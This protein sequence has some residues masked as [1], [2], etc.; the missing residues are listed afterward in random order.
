MAGKASYQRF[1]IECLLFAGKYTYKCISLFK[2]E[3]DQIFKKVL[4]RLDLFFQEQHLMNWIR[5]NARVWEPFGNSEILESSSEEGDSSEEE[6]LEESSPIFADKV[7]R[8]KK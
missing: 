6:E 4:E 5:H 8:I 1:F 7:K 2:E 3:K